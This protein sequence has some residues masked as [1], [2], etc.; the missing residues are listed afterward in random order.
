MRP[1][2]RDDLAW[3]TA[4]PEYV[5][6]WRS[7]ALSAQLELPVVE[8]F[9][10]RRELVLQ[11][12]PGGGD[13]LRLDPISQGPIILLREEHRCVPEVGMQPDRQPGRAPA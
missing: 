2:A 11:A 8:P 13:D 6:E 1:E 9:S 3:P 10:A 5:F 4:V 12:A 7:V